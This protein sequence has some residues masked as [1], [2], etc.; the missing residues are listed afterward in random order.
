MRQ[1]KLGTGRSRCLSFQPLMLIDKMKSG[2]GE[3]SARE[4]TWLIGKWLLRRS[5][6]RYTLVDLALDVRSRIQTYE[7]WKPT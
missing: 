5:L 2:E 6:H 1:G 3:A 7:T 4:A